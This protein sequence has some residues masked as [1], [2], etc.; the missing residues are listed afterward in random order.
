MESYGVIRISHQSKNQ[1]F[2]SKRSFW[3][4]WSVWILSCNIISKSF[5]AINTFVDFWNQIFK[6]QSL[7]FEG[8]SL[9]E[10]SHHNCK[11]VVFLQYGSSHEYFVTYTTFEWLCSSMNC[12]HVLIHGTLMWKIVVTKFTFERPNSFMNR[13]QMYFQGTL[14]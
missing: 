1:N 10:F 2:I 6:I 9:L 11:H 7:S 8:V 3:S 14:L 5:R 4:L 13:C 12:W